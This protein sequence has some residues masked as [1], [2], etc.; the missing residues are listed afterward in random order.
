[1]EVHLQLKRLSAFTEPD[2]GVLTPESLRSCA[3]DLRASIA[4]FVAG[5]SRRALG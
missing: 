1:M 2:A 4:T 5:S 3:N